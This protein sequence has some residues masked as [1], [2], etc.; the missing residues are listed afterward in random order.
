[1]QDIFFR[2]LPHWH[3][4]NATFFVT[5]RLAGSLP[6]SVL[7]TLDW[8]WEQE[9][10]RLA[11]QFQGSEL[12]NQRYALSKRY[13]ARFD[14]H[15]DRADGPRWLADP[16]LAGIVRDEIHALHPEH[17]HLLA[18]CI[19]PNHVHL[20]IDLQDIPNPPPQRTGQTFTALSHALYLLKGHTGRACRQL[21]GGNGPFWQHESY[22]HVVRDE[23]ELKNIVWYILNNPVQAG[24]AQDWQEWPFTFVDE[25]L[26]P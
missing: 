1:M 24:L 25:N 8:E 12:E 2:H 13:F 18:F 23:A 10:A 4:P 21:L 14:G 22:D 6:R 17:Y 26:L 9:K 5:F 11:S 7:Q 16:R 20:L 15:L 19:M 3:P